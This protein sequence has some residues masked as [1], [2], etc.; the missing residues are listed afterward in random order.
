MKQGTIAIW[1]LGLLL[2]ASQ[3]TAAEPARPADPGGVA[4]PAAPAPAVADAGGAPVVI[5]DLPENEAEIA[6]AAA[7]Q[8]RIGTPAEPAAAV[9]VALPVSPE[10]AEI[11]A[12]LADERARVA[13]LQ[14]R[15]DDTADDEAA[16]ALLREMEQ[17]KQA[18][19]VEVL[20]IQAK[21]ARL[22]GRD[23]QATEIEAAIAVIL[24]PTPV[25]PPAHA[26]DGR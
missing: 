21:H 2:L 12:A 7:G 24:A 6:A 20:R 8:L 5:P 4:F 22:A 3:G 11:N 19:E 17:T 26:T 9:P 18:T 16:L 14:A 10:M 25:A 1:V 13:G 23:A 15:L